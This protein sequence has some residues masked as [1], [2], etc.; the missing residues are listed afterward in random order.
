M[1]LR[2]WF[3]CHTSLQVGN[4]VDNDSLS[5]QNR[6]C[7]PTF[8]RR[9]LQSPKTQLSNVS[10]KLELVIDT[11]I[12]ATANQRCTPD[13]LLMTPVVIA[14]QWHLS[15]CS[16]LICKSIVVIMI[17]VCYVKYPRPKGPYNVSQV[18]LE[19]AEGIPDGPARGPIGR[20]VHF[21]DTS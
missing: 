6:F 10:A 3:L 18:F 12:K 9:L 17:N 14:S 20:L 21:Y 8:C 2:N 16:T 7:R 11:N 13:G 4:T 19:A 1:R 15:L 5:L